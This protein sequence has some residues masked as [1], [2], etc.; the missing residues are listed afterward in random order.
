MP[1]KRRRLKL[2][3]MQEIARKATRAALV[4][5]RRLSAEEDARLTLGSG[6]DGDDG[7]FELYL[8]AER[9]QD[10]KVISRATVNRY[11]GD[12]RVEVFLEKLEA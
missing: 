12:V 5:F 4:P 1:E 10:A 7:V 2:D 6:I 8:A 9:P 11:T 3:E